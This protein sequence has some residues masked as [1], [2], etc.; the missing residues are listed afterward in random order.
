MKLNKNLVIGMALLT[1]LSTGV[2]AQTYYVG[3][4]SFNLPQISVQ[5]N[6]VTNTTEHTY[7]ACLSSLDGTTNAV[8]MNQGD[9]CEANP[10]SFTPTSSNTGNHTYAVAIEYNTRVWNPTTGWQTISNGID[11]NLTYN[12]EVQNIPT[13]DFSVTSWV[14]GLL[15]NVQTW[16]CS[17]LGLFCPASGGGGNTNTTIVL[18]TTNADCANTF[19]PTQCVSGTCQ[20]IGNI[21]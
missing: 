19:C 4:Q 8:S 3:S 11:N 17:N 13:D 7:F 2:F 10:I 9:L 12:F 1:I 20:R 5:G 14:S 15:Q 18:C 21:C 6:Y 16:F